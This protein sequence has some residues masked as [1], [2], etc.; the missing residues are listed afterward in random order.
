MFIYLTLF[1]TVNHN[2]VNI[3]KIFHKKCFGT[4]LKLKFVTKAKPILTV[5][6]LSSPKFTFISWMPE[7][8][9]LVVKDYERIILDLDWNWKSW[10]D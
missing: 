9:A 3:P 5:T 1:L 10:I 8:C 7:K 2:W 6:T 4:T